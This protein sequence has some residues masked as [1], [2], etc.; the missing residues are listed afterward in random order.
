MLCA[1]IDA[2]AFEICICECECKVVFRF[3]ETISINLFCKVIGKKTFVKW[4]IGPE[5]NGALEDTA[6]MNVTRVK[7]F[8]HGL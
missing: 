6:G 1:Y 8:E 2:K 4:I 7:N 5:R 3:V